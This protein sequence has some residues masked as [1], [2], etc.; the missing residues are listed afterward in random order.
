[1]SYRAVLL[2]ENPT[3]AQLQNIVPDY[4]AMLVEVMTALAERYERRPDYPFI[5]TKLDLISGDDFPDDDPV[6]GLDTIY[7]WIQG[8][9]L[10]ALA[11]HLLWLHRHPIAADLPPRLARM[12]SDLLM[13]LRRMRARNAGHLHF[14]MTPDGEPFTL[15]ANGRQRTFV[16]ELDTPYG[17]S[18][19]F[20][21][22]GMYA[23]AR[24]LGDV[25][26]AAEAR[27]YCLAV[28]EAVHQGNFTSDQQ[29]LDP[30]NPVQP[31]PGRHLHGPYMLQLGTAALMASLEAD[32]SCVEFGLRQI[33]Y[34][35]AHHINLHGRHAKLHDNDFW[36]AIDD[37][38]QPYLDA[39]FH[40]VCDPGHALE[41]VGLA[42]KFTQAVNQ[43]Q[44]ATAA[45]QKEI[46]DIEAAMPAI[47]Q[48]NFACGFQPGSGGICKAFDLLSRRPIN[49]DMPW[50]NLPETLRAALLCHNVAAAETR[51]TCLAIFAACHNAFTRHYVRPDLHLMAVQT[52]SAQGR[53]VPV[54]PAT[55]DADPGY[56]TGLSLIDVLE[57]LA[58]GG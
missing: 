8:R 32:A 15:D 6:R 50:W 51:Q 49:T 20:C 11:L 33:R 41:Y 7:G 16:P 23:T 36:E 30:Q 28:D 27:A 39:N 13:Q 12:M 18:D 1:M 24:V 25:E 56:H 37:G 45:Q 52:R 58:S 42:L 5:D 3:L 54:I 31:V 38:G 48:H 34:E 9:G 17:Y 29:P 21:A 43:T 19:L 57:T 53:P 35:M 26:A 10:E 47:L 22:K 55:A 14:F 44:L 46:A 2:P 4:Q 40:I